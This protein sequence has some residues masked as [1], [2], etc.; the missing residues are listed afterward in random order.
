MGKPRTRP[1]QK[2]PR[3]FYELLSVVGI[4]CGSM[5]QKYLLLVEFIR[6]KVTELVRALFNTH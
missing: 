6:K 3:S 2:L 4:P 5:S 1:G